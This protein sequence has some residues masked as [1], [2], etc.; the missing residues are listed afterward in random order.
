MVKIIKGTYGHKV[1]KVI[2]P[3][4]AGETVELTAEQEARLIKLGVAEK[5]ETVPAGKGEPGEQNENPAGEGS[6]E[7]EQLPEY[8][9]SMKL[10]EL[11]A[12]AAQYG[13]D[14]SSIKTKKDVVAAIDAARAEL[15]PTGGNA[16]DSVVE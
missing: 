14:A 11:K 5:V 2:K 4:I 1:G 15:P 9:E 7:V 10:D 12:I 13:V 8:N 6:G 3:V 16:S